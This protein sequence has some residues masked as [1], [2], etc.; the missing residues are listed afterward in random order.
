MFNPFPETAVVDMTFAVPEG[1]RRPNELQAFPVDGGSVVVVDVGAV[2]TRYGQVSA[3][4][5][6]RSGRIVVDRIQTFDGSAGPR[7]MD[8]T[9]GAP[10]PGP[11]WFFPSGIT[12]DGVS[13]VF[14]VF[15]PDEEST[16]EVDLEVALE[17][18][19]TN[20][21]VDPFEISVPPSG[22]CR[23]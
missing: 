7:G 11:L 3:A 16:A 22:S 14:S 20:G 19:A 5:T 1:A 2:V 18:P 9:L 4:V 17:D 23:W 6:A 12:G 10:R 15:N 8:V 21:A 13:E